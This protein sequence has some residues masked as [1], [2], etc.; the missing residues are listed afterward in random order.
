MIDGYTPP[1]SR[2]EFPKQI[3]KPKV[4]SVDI[5]RTPP[6]VDG[7]KIILQRHE[8]YQRE[9]VEGGV[10]L[11]S[12]TTESMQ[13][14]YKQ[15]REILAE[16]LD[17]VPVEE[18]SNVSFLVVGSSTKFRDQGMRSIETAQQVLRGLKDELEDEQLG[19]NQIEN[20]HSVLQDVAT[21]DA[22]QA[23]RFLDDSK[24]YFSFLKEKYGDETQ[25]FWK[26]FEEDAHKKERIQFGAEGP[27]EIDERFT[28]Y[29]EKLTRYARHFHKKNSEK[30][31]VIWVVSH[32]DTVSPFIK[33]HVTKT[34]PHQFIDVDYGAG[35]SVEID[36]AEKVLSF[37][38]GKKYDVDLNK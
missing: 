27:D 34:D 16:M 6:D 25:A 26:A 35:I 8:R 32:Y 24:D 7:T 21:I 19:Q 36:S 10:A 14:A 37:F 22:I 11:G 31:L 38:H 23:P 29:L 2:M 13:K 15:T 1:E 28:H 18:R 4:D 12:L 9:V 33:R 5:N 3:E 30:R 17:S 20:N